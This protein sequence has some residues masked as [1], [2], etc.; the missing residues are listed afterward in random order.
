M[1]PFTQGLLDK[2]AAAEELI[3]SQHELLECFR[4]HRGKVHAAKRVSAAAVAWGQ[5]SVSQAKAANA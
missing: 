2:L 4:L 5:A 3:E 1:D